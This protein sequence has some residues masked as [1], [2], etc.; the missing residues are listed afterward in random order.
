MAQKHDTTDEQY[1]RLIELLSNYD[2]TLE[3][4]QKGFQDGYI[5]L[6]RSNYYNKDSLRGNYG[7]DYWDETYIG[8][9]MAT[10]EEKLQGSCRNRQKKAEDK[11]ERERGRDNKLTQRKRN[12]ARKAKNSESQT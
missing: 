7:E 8:Q 9:L 3:Q 4:L 5:Q 1:L 2:S 10:V 11:Q 12:E 6:S